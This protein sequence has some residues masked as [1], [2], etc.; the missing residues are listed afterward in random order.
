[1]INTK[2]QTIEEESDGEDSNDEAEVTVD[3]QAR[4]HNRSQEEMPEV[5]QF[6]LLAEE[7]YD[8][9][10]RGLTSSEQ[11][12]WKQV[13]DGVEIAEVEE[14]RYKPFYTAGPSMNSRTPLASKPLAAKKDRISF[15]SSSKG[16]TN[17][18]TCPMCEREFKGSETGFT[19]HANM[20][21]GMPSP[22]AVYS[23]PSG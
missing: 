3:V 11:E 10:G 22:F 2:P 9:V 6:D 15:E 13:D 4:I 14:E 19:R 17:E 8:E 5:D 20:C 12:L 7:E 1:M 16:P 21:L 18:W 23:R